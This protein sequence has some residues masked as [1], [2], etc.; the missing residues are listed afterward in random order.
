MSHASDF[1]PMTSFRPRPIDVDKPMPVLHEDIED[2]LTSRPL[3]AN[4]AT[5]MESHEENESHIKKAIEEAARKK[6]KIQAN[7]PTPTCR[8]VEYYEEMH[9]DDFHPGEE[10][11]TYQQPVNIFEEPDVGMVEYDMDLEDVA[12]VEKLNKENGA[13]AAA[14]AAVAKGGGGRGVE[15]THASLGGRP[16]TNGTHS[17]TAAGV[18]GGIRDSGKEIKTETPPGYVVGPDGEL[19]KK[20]RPVG[21]PRKYP[22]QPKV[23]RALQESEFE[24]VMD[25]LEREQAKNLVLPPAAASLGAEG[26]VTLQYF[27]RRM[28][29]SEKCTLQPEIITA[30]YL[31]WVGKRNQAGGPLL[32]R[33][34]PRPKAD[35]P[36]PWIA[37]RPR[38]KDPKYKRPRRSNAQV[39]SRIRHLKREMATAQMLLELVVK[40]EKDKKELLRVS[41]RHFE[42]D[43]V[44]TERNLKDVP[45]PEPSDPMEDDYE[46]DEP[47]VFRRERS[48]PRKKPPPVVEEELQVGDLT[49][50]S[51]REFDRFPPHR[52]HTYLDPPEE[53]HWG[54]VSLPGM[55]PFRGRARIGR[56]GRVMFDRWFDPSV[57]PRYYSSS[58]SDSEELS[59]DSDLE[60]L[61]DFSTGFDRDFLA[62]LA[63]LNVSHRFCGALPQ[64]T[65]EEEDVEMQESSYGAGK[66]SVGSPALFYHSSREG[67]RTGLPLISAEDGFS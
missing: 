52:H 34:K 9:P 22:V 5:G 14:E 45:V 64:S 63:G 44:H 47:L 15:G 11:V 32:D 53:K 36:S 2:D 55:R 61:E 16:V 27:S 12:F 35:D 33:Y 65:E 62:S 30:I 48:V 60:A 50:E 19:K 57:P 6:T 1:L 49:L 42:L 67:E 3:V 8:I 58:E 54:T 37:F 26:F 20:K 40:R 41:K 59:S 18:G 13:L 4:V 39:M 38:D 28:A 7:I 66:D 31:H 10:F 25:R 24:F 21:R 46:E 56:G 23:P 43:L 51:E 29:D 17:L